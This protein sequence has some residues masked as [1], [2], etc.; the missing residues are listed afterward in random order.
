MATSKETINYKLPIYAPN[1]VT[2]YLVT[3]NGAMTLLDTTLANIQKMAE[4]AGAD[5]TLVESSVKQIKEAVQL[6]NANVVKNTENIQSNT[7][8]IA[9]MKI[10]LSN[11]DG[12]V[13]NLK[14]EVEEAIDKV[15]TEY[16]GVIGVGENTLTVNTPNLTA[17]SLI[18]VYTDEYGLVPKNV[19]ANITEK[20]VTVTVD[21]RETTL[22]VAVVVR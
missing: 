1:D 12:K 5:V 4:T 10:N 6:L 14:A 16:K 11:L 20:L 7:E 17:D 19:T 15:G 18:D 22:Q 9:G 2:S 3:W 21:S 13:V 8:D